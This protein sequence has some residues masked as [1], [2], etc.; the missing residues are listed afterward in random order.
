[1]AVGGVVCLGFLLW[2]LL[3]NERERLT[4][5]SAFISRNKQNL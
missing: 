1:M 2:S 3:Q 5:L 4:K